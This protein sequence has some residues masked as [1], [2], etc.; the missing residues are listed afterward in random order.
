MGRAC[1]IA[2]FQIQGGVNINCK[3][4]EKDADSWCDSEAI[5]YNQRL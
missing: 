2:F 3:T 5:T 4:E 1:H